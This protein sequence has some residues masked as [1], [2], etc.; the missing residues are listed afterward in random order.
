[1]KQ[2]ATQKNSVLRQEKLV[3]SR[4]WNV[5]KNW[6]LYLMFLPVLAYFIIF[7]YVPMYGVQIAFKDFA[8]TLGIW[9]SPWVGL[10]HFK[11]FFN[12]AYFSEIL[13]NTVTISLYSLIVGFPLPI[14]LALSLNEVRNIR[15]KKL[16]QTVSYAPY[17]ISTVV[18]SGIII[19]FLAPDTGII[20]IIR[21][22]FGGE[23]IHFMYQGRMFKSIYVWSGVWQ[24]TGYGSI[25]YLSALAT[26]DPQ[27]HEAAVIDGASRLQRIWHI[28][29]PGILPTISIMLIMNFGSIMNV[30]FEKIFLLMNSLNRSYAEV[31][32]TFVYSTGLLQSQYSFSAAVGLF[33]SVINLV[34]LVTVNQV[35]KRLDQSTLF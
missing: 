17:F 32:S 16:V 22:F 1:M 4:F 26:I 18:M 27:L 33:N 9:G 11:R 34:L 24:G 3:G 7:H 23:S 29:I 5:F 8:G 30:G 20:N 6:Q 31:I 35:V 10:E 28:N 14:I 2:Q 25:I 15:F 12:S 21:E 13:W 19:L